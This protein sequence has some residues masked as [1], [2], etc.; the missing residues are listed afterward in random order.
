MLSW[1]DGLT[2][3][4]PWARQSLSTKERGPVDERGEVQGAVLREVAAVLADE[5]VFGGEDA[6][7]PVAIERERH[8]IDVVSVPALFHLTVRLFKFAV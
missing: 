2:N 5:L 1:F 8:E 7:A 4:M 6:D 3:L